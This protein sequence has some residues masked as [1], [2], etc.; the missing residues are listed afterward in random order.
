MP[1]TQSAT[2]SKTTLK[3]GKSTLGKSGTTKTTGNFIT[4]EQRFRM[5][6][7]AAYFIAEKRGF[8]E[9][10]IQGDWL[11]AETEIDEMLTNQ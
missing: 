10:D 1:T 9:G 8:S 6:A 4:P 3:T 5:I 2:S 7:E 11:R